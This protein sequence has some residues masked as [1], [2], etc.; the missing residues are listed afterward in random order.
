[1]AYDE[2]FFKYKLE[3]AKNNID[4]ELKAHPRF[5]ELLKIGCERITGLVEANDYGISISEDGKTIRIVA[6]GYNK[7]TR[8]E[9]KSNTRLATFKM[10]LTDEGAIITELA[11]GTLYRTSDLKL[12]GVEVKDTN[13]P[14]T[15]DTFYEGTYYDANGIELCQSRYTDSIELAE[16]MNKMNKM[17]LYSLIVDSIYSPNFK[18]IPMMLPDYCYAGRSAQYYRMADDIGVGYCRLVDGIDKNGR[19]SLA[20]TKDDIYMICPQN[21][22][23]PERLSVL[24]GSPAASFDATKGLSGEFVVLD[25]KLFGENVEETKEILRET[26]ED[27]LENSDL[28]ETKPEQYQA[29]REYMN[30]SRQR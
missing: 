13:K 18:T 29:L 20:K 1:M 12:I 23:K 21:L 30:K 28:K 9:L 14:S 15:M 10:T 17:N 7:H 24:V 16:E 4:V 11:D 25:T 27:C 2:N 26:F 22:A 8:D 19:Y 3:N 5:E 6:E